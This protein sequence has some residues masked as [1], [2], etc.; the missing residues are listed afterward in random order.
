TP[1][2]RLQHNDEL[3][4]LFTAWAADQHKK[5][6][7]NRAGPMRGPVAYAHS[8]QDL[9]D[10]PQLAARGYWHELDHP[11]AGR[12]TYPGAPILMSDSP[13]RAGR[14]P[15]LGE[16]GNGQWA[17]GNGRSALTPPFGPPSPASGGEGAEHGEAGEG[18]PSL[19]LETVRV[20][21]LTM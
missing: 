4:A 10:S 6:V 17:T 20:L 7:Y 3:S 19:P 13:W 5:E 15:L 11:V 14:A 21:D 8:L 9:R 2:A 18:R 16:E 12:L 1:A